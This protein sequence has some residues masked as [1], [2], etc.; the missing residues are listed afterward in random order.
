MARLRSILLLLSL[1]A[2]SLVFSGCSDDRPATG[3]DA[4]YTGPRQKTADEL[5]EEEENRPPYVGMTKEEAFQRYGNPK[6]DIVTDQGERVVWFLNE[7]EVLG[8]SLI[9]FYIPPRPRFATLF[10][11]PDGRVRDFH[12]DAR[13][14]R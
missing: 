11:G 4:A 7:G 9:P 5:R 10:F 2:V 12:F 14:T 1:G 13:E 6:S 3:K 8:K